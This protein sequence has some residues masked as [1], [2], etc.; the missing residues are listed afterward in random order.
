MAK[1]GQNEA[2][3]RES[4]RMFISTSALPLARIDSFSDEDSFLEKGIL[5][6]TSVLELVGHI[7]SEYAF[8]VEPDEI[9]PDNLDSINKL[10]GFIARKTAPA[11]AKS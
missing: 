3:I 11:S 5:D 7:E 6:S 2:E 4:L 8:R 9:I 10:T 1:D